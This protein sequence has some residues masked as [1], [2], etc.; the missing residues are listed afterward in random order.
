MLRANSLAL[1]SCVK[2]GIVT[3]EFGVLEQGA[4]FQHTNN[5]VS[6]KQS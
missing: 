6:I 4:A 3:T 2:F 5:H 1:Q